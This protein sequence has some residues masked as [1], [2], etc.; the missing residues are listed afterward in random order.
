MIVFIACVLLWEVSYILL[1]H[2]YWAVC[3]CDVCCEGYGVRT[4][5]QCRCPGRKFWRQWWKFYDLHFVP[6]FCVRACQTQMPT[7]EHRNNQ[8]LKWEYPRFAA[9][10]VCAALF[11]AEHLTP[12]IAA[13]KIPTWMQITQILAS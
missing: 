10:L 12:L 8:K 1:F 6:A 9:V 3:M 5:C 7:L 4:F 11:S 13:E 2:V